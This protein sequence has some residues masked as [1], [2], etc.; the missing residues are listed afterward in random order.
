[1]ISKPNTMK[2]HINIEAANKELDQIKDRVKQLEKIISV[3][4]SDVKTWLFT[5]QDACDDQ[6]VD[7]AEFLKKC[8]GLEDDEIAYRQAKIV[9]AAANQGWIPDYNKDEDKYEPR[10]NMRTG[11]GFAF[12]NTCCAY[13]HS[14]AYVGSHLCFK[15]YEIMAHVCTQPIFVAIY[16]RL[17]CK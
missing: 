11:S 7:H 1:M 4:R 8:I 2:Q 9:V 12:S 13:W 3:D 17:Y 10:W 5:F 14:S 15:N 16:K 6:G